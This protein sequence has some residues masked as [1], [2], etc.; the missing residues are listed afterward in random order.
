MFKEA[1]PEKAKQLEE[2]LEQ[3]YLE[4]AG[5]MLE[6]AH[7]SDAAFLITELPSKLRPN[8]LLLVNKTKAAEIV[9]ELPD[10]VRETAISAM[11]PKDAA[12]ILGEMYTDEEADVLQALK[13]EKAEA[14]LK[15][16]RAKDAAEMRELMVY[17]E[18]TV[19]GLMQKEYIAIPSSFTAAETVRYLRANASTFL[20]FP[21]S[22]LYAVNEEG[23]FLGVV[24]L[25]SL[26]LCEGSTP[27]EKLM[28]RE[29]VYLLASDSAEEAVK[30]FE[31]Y[32]YIALP[33]VD[34]EH[35][36]IGVVLQEDAFDYA[37]KEGEE[38]M[39]RASGIL[40]G[41]ELREMP[42]LARV[43]NRLFWLGAKV[44]LNLV[45][46]SVVAAHE[47]T[48]RDL[49]LLAILLPIT[50]DLGGG[51]GSQSTAVSIRE[52]AK[53]RLQPKEYLEV[54]FKELPLGL[55]N[56]LILGTLTGVVMGLWK[57]N[58]AFGVLAAS[59]ISLNTLIAAIIGGI[60]P[61]FLKRIQADP[62]TASMPL[63]TTITDTIGFW[64]VL[65]LALPIM[66]FIG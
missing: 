7:P 1:T 60:L 47:Q 66:R 16:L 10:D 27:V 50:S 20:D 58:F 44:L 51:A 54:F 8:A 19:G 18:D 63:L 34:E 21:A 13:P 36:L 61:L 23:K 59:A 55:L 11:K 2:L 15:E 4:E 28:E 43:V 9:E 38:E 39:M 29:P 40:G 53:E 49:P 37:Q 45:P 32:H 25:R 31:K 56:G 62:A 30:A 33:V 41:E 42:I 46:A 26:L 3:G 24:T 57:N 5:A 35:N 6:A 64:L 48:L 65:G 14:I 12:A 17:P 52:L 22:Y